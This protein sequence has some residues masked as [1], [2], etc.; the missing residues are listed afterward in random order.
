[1]QQKLQKL[2]SVMVNKLIVEDNIEC[3]FPNVKISLS[4]VPVTTKALCF[5][6][7]ELISCHI[8][9]TNLGMLYSH[10]YVHTSRITVLVFN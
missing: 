1:V 5:L 3:A 4:V 6:S 7:S 10:I 9:E 8:Y 2:D